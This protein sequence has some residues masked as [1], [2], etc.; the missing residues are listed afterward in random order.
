MSATIEPAVSGLHHITLVAGDAQ[1]TVDFYTGLL[2]LRL[3]KRTVNFD[4]PGSY[5]LYFGN[6]TADPGSLVTFFEWPDTPRG[7]PGIG[8]THHFA[9]TVE[10]D[11]ALE[12]WKRRIEAA[13]RHVAGVFD[14]RYF[15]SIYFTD[16]DGQVVEIAT[17]APGFTVD[18]A[19]QALGTG[20]KP[21]PGERAG[22]DGTVSTL[23]AESSKDSGGSAP[24]DST[25]H[26][27]GERQPVGIDPGMRL[28]A[29][30]HHISAIVAD[31]ERSDAFYSGVLGLRRVK[32]TANFDDPSSAHWY[33][34]RENG[35]PGTLMT[36]FEWKK[37]GSAHARIGRGQTHHVA[38]AVPDETSQLEWR[39]R[40]LGLG[41]P[42]SPVRDRVYFKSIYLQDPD[43]HI[44]ELATNGPGFAV[45]EDPARLGMELR[46]PP[47]LEKHHDSIAGSLATLTIPDPIQ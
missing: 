33:W 36:A 11:E 47:W 3:V 39:E 45:D 15:R 16:P 38:F 8:G 13:G 25:P 35:T 4:D 29:G 7:R 17:R 18:E 20:F 21:A 22:G 23:P 26:R 10:S 12:R 34:G 46:L 1:R 14:R 27:A 28:S 43:G 24:V 42:V 9:L 32:M 19:V 41:L 30:L 31:I 37:P 40:L 6:D 44:I 5:H 2:G